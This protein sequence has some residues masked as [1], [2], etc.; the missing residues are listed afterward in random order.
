MRKANL[1]KLLAQ[2][3]VST[4]QSRNDSSPICYNVVDHVMKLT[5][6]CSL[7]TH[8]KHNTTVIEYLP[9]ARVVHKTIV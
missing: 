1:H 5:V 4:T 3:T 8:C 6:I 2:T 7:K 9:S